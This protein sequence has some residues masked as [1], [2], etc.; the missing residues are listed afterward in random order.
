MNPWL[1]MAC[2]GLVTYLIRLSL[3]ALLGRV[4]VPPLVQRGLRFVPPAVLSAIVFPELLRP[5]GAFALSLGNVRLLA[6]VLA[7]LIA[8]R[9][10]NVFLTI[11]VGMLALWALRALL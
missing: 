3:I 5:N 11:A 6:G 1:T 2:M 8:W 4:E 9:T 10:K 7:A